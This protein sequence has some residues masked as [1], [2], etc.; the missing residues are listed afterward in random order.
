MEQTSEIETVLLL[1]FKLAE[2]QITSAIFRFASEEGY[3][4]GKLNIQ[5]S[6]FLII[7]TAVP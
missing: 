4:L 5:T 1:K 3:I 7:E 2:P 6:L